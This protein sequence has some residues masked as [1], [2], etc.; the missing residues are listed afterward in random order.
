MPRLQQSF[1]T[2]PD[3]LQISRELPGKFLV[4]NMDGI[5]TSGMITEVE[6]YAGI[7]DK[8]S[9]AYN[10]RRTKRTE[11]MF[12]AG[13]TAYVYLCYGIHQLFNIVTNESDTPHAILI[14][15]IEPAEGVDEMLLRRNKLKIDYTLTKGPGSVSKAL[16]IK[17][18]HSGISLSGNTIWLEDRKVKFSSREIIATTRV[19]VDYAGDAAHW[20]YRFFVKGNPWVSRI[21]K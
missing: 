14:R 10:G 11:V 13:G 9:H 15:S 7:I 3:V 5:K 19:G 21:P 1:Y 2:R 18:Q 16:G 20:L 4:T 8:A 17:T 6:A 12:G